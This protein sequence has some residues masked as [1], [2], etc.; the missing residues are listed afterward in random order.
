MIP[1][2]G[3]INSFTRS[4]TGPIDDPFA[5]DVVLYLKGNGT[6][7]STSIIDETGKTVT[8]VGNTNIS[9]AQSKYGG[10]SIYFDGDGDILAIQSSS[11]WNLSLNNNYTLECWFYSINTTGFRGII[12]TLIRTTAFSGWLIRLEGS[13][14]K[15]LNRDVVVYS[16]PI[17]TSEWYHMAL[18]KQDGST[19]FALNGN[20]GSTFPNS[21]NFSDRELII[22]GTYPIN[23]P[24]GEHFM[25]Y[26][27][28]LRITKGVARYTANFNPETDTY[29]NS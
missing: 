4:I 29:L 11:D 23:Y 8:V 13:N 21:T 3:S 25:G 5:D 7:G 1:L 22:G 26:I 19:R 10:S 18:V 28:S 6:D 15:V 9:T 2:I 16:V 14:V 24:I 20:F 27:D 17:T 12:S